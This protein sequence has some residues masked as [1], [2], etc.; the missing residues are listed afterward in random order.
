MKYEPVEKLSGK[1]LDMNRA[2]DSLKEEVEAVTAYNQRAE[3]CEALMLLIAELE[4]A[5]V[6][7]EEAKA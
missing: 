2:I 5:P 4:E 7:K 1:T 3:A 6:N